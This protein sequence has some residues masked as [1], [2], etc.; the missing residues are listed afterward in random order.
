MKAKMQ[1]YMEILRQ[2]GQMPD[3]YEEPDLGEMEGEQPEMEYEAE[4]YEAKEK[5][6]KS[7]KGKGY[8]E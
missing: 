3:K 6:E 8:A 4:E 5:P 7:E 2:L 1:I